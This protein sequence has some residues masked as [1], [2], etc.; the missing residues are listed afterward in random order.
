MAA[1]CVQKYGFIAHRES[2]CVL[3]HTDVISLIHSGESIRWHG[4]RVTQIILTKI[5]YLCWLTG[6][7]YQNAHISAH[8]EL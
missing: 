6:L 4:E 2:Y 5:I 1:C 3:N 8:L 7:I